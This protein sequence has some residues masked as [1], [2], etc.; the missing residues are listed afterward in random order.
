MCRCRGCIPGV[1]MACRSHQLST[2]LSPRARR[3]RAVVIRLT[4]IGCMLTHAVPAASQDRS[5]RDVLSF[6]VTN[7]AIPTADLVKDREAAQATLNTLGQAL[8]VDLA[9]LPVGTSSSAFTYRF[10]PSLG[11]LE[12]LAQSFGPFLVDRALTTG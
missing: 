9:T 6:L 1:N 7:Q 12:R 8:L 5:M 3:V 4:W 11:T 10:N 2:V